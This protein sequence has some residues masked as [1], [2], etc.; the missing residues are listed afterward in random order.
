MKTTSL[1]EIKEKANKWKDIHVQ[2]LEDNIVKM[3]VLPKLIYRL[4]TFSI[5]IPGTVFAET[6]K[7]ILKFIRKCQNKNSQNLIKEQTW[8]THTSLCQNLLRIYSYQDSVKLAYE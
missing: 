3:A 4:N 7:L 2:R 5:K 6:D 8:R 1:T